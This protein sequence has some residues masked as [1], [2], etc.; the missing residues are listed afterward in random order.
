MYIVFGVEYQMYK[1]MF[2]F[3][4]QKQSTAATKKFMHAAGLWAKAYDKM[5]EHKNLVVEF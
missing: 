2:L 4:V 1:K 3:L 5:E